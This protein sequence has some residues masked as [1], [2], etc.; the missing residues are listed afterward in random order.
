MT[1]FFELINLSAVHI[2]HSML[3]LC[4]LSSIVRG[5]Y[6]HQRHSSSPRVVA[7]TPDSWGEGVS[8]SNTYYQKSITWSPCGHFV[9]AVVGGTGEAVEVRDAL[10]SELISTFTKPAHYCDCGLAYSP[11][12][13]SLA[14]LS[15]TLII[16]DIQTGGAAKKIQ[17]DG[18]ENG[19]ITW[20]LDG[21]QG[22]RG[23]HQNRC[24]R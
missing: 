18:S 5:L 16:W 9:A 17:Y 14:H 8:I 3:E 13:C 21:C 2:Y 10:S 12:G 24:T 19:S 11:D 15:D 22:R 4:P 20:S 1:K 7:G 23:D 6:Y